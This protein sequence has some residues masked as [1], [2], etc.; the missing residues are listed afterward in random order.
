V[1]FVTY[2][3]PVILIAEVPL[4][5]IARKDL[6][7]NSG[8]TGGFQTTVTYYIWQISAVTNA[9]DRPI[10]DVHLPVYPIA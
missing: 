8:N 6:P 1:T 2:F 10:W 7:V 3:T 5:L 9:G 4:V